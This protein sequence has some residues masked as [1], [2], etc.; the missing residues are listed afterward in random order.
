MIIGI[1]SD[2]LDIRRIEKLLDD[3]GERFI[4]RCFTEEE[5]VKAERRCGAGLHIA[6]YAKRFAA[7]EA[8]AK[9]LGTGFQDGVAMKDIGVVNSSHGQPELVLTGRAQEKL[10]ALMPENM[11]PCLHLSLSD[12]PPMVIAHVV[13]EAC[14][15]KI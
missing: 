5:V 7:K 11:R 9:A 6:S 13:I 15:E 2:L 10:E 12:E 4:E 8:C 1:G 14:P 3:Q